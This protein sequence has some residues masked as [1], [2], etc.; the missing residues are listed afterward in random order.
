MEKREMRSPSSPPPASVSRTPPATHR[1]CANAATCN[2]FWRVVFQGSPHFSCAVAMFRRSAP[3]LSSSS[4]ACCQPSIHDQS[5]AATR[6]RVFKLPCAASRPIS[7]WSPRTDEPGRCA[8]IF[9]HVVSVYG[10]LCAVVCLVRGERSRR[11]LP[12]SRHHPLHSTNRIQWVGT[13]RLAAKSHRRHGLII[14]V[15]LGLGTSRPSN[16]DG[17]GRA[18]P[19]CYA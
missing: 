6:A 17:C 8:I 7:A 4:R 2:I 9:V 3:A 1:A 5:R 15:P 18:M 14:A 16:S 11:H 12:S 13:G 10:R 19:W